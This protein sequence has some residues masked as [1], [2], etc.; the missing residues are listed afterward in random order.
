MKTK[1][2]EMDSPLPT[3][4]RSI[5][6]FARSN[7]GG[8]R[9]RLDV[10][11]HLAHFAR[12]NDG[13]DQLH[14][15][16]TGH[17]AFSLSR[18]RRSACQGLGRQPVMVSAVM[19]STLRRSGPRPSSCHGIRAKDSHNKFAQRIC[20]PNLCHGYSQAEN[21]YIA[22]CGWEIPYQVRKNLSA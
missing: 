21:P 3:L 6:P 9:L 4:I 8:D 5:A 20:V 10:T 14:L 18:S 12:S 7:D 17:L 16:V 1:T 13:G 22:R 19:V 11:G 2:A 15:D